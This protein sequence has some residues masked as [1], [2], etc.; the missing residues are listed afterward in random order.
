MKNFVEC[1][2]CHKKLKQIQENRHLKTHNI[3]KKEYLKKFPN[4]ELVPYNRRMHMSKV[5]KKT[6]YNK[7]LNMSFEEKQKVTLNAN[8]KTRKMV[9]KGEWILQTKNRNFVSWFADK[10][11]EIYKKTSKK[12]SDIKIE[13][14]QNTV[15]VNIFW[16]KVKENPQNYKKLF[17]YL[18]KNKKE[19]QNGKAAYMCS[20]NKSSSKGQVKL[21]EE[22][23]EKYPSAILNYPI[24]VK[25]NKWYVLDVFIPKKNLC[26]EYDGLYWHKDTKEK[27]Q[28][29]DADLQQIGIAT[30]RIN[31]G[32]TYTIQ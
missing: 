24:K 7:Y 8:K 15:A 32:E 4:A 18:K 10:N 26:Y 1:L 11:S 16:K 3:T 13:T 19:M 31:E 29:R 14:G 12:I 23:K 20:R 2:I 22:I 6:M 30:I 5:A 27:D 28:Q 25:S 9:K 17:K 21:F